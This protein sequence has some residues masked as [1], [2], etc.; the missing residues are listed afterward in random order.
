[1]NTCEES[2]SACIIKLL[3]LKGF[4]RPLESTQP[5]TF[6]HENVILSTNSTAWKYLAQLHTAGPGVGCRI[7]DSQ[8]QAL[9]KHFIILKN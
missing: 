7:L 8:C 4:G 5:P 6:I 3:G 2:I 9:W 1:M